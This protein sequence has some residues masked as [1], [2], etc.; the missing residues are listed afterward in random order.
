M[1]PYQIY[2]AVYLLIFLVSRIFKKN[3][4]T[5]DTIESIPDVE[6]IS[7]ALGSIWQIDD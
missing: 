1:E 5:T 6:M 4:Y 2:A 3:E 7:S